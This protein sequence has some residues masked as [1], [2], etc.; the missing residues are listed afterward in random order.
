MQRELK[1]DREIRVRKNTCSQRISNSCNLV[2]SKTHNSYVT[3]NASQ[4]S[5]IFSNESAKNEA[6]ITKI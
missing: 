3:C 6:I 1:L 4:R 2:L 5:G